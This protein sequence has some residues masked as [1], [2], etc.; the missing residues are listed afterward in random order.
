MASGSEPILGVWGREAPTGS[1]GRVPGRGSGGP[2]PPEAEHF[3]N[4]GHV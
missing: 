4:V 1:R 3:P 2:L